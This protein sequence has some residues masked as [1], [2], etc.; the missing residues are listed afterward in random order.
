MTFRTN[1]STATT[2]PMPLSL[3]HGIAYALP[4]LT[5][6]LLYGP[7]AIMQGIYAKYFGVALTTIATVILVARLFDALSDPLIGYFSDRYYARRGSRKPFV[8]IGGLLLIFSSYFLYVPVDPDAV[9]ASTTISTSYFLGWFLMF[10]LAYTLFEVPHLAW[11]GELSADSAGKNKIFS[12]RVLFILLGQ[13]IF[14][15]TPLL[16]MF[17]DHEFTPHTLKWSVLTAGV[18]MLPVLYFCVKAVPN[19]QSVPVSSDHKCSGGGN[20]SLRLVWSSIIDNTPFVIFITAYF[21][22]MVGFGMWYGLLFSYSDAYLGLSHK[23]P[24]IYGI[25]LSVS[26]LSIGVWHK[27]AIHWGKK[28]TWILGILIASLGIVSTGLLVPGIQHWVS[29]CV[30]MTFIYVGFM[31]VNI[32]APSWLADIIDYG[33]WKFGSDHAGSYFSLYT[34]TQKVNVAIGGALG[35]AI[36]A[37][38]GFDPTLTVHNVD[39]VFG[40]Q[41]AIVW[42]PLGIVLLSTVFVALIPMNA[43]RHATI[44]RRLQS[45]RERAVAQEECVGIHQKLT[46]AEQQTLTSL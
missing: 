8:V 25:S 9:T 11:G 32:L 45:R 29:L 33:T 14:F 42:I 39:V 20:E 17:E 35:L 22:I 37:W 3:Q 44:S 27:L 12:L 19:G 38:Y 15:S 7:V 40:V 13:I 24:L 43:R 6:N 36:A 31:A 34:L 21:F 2:I 46:D 18:L 1:Q 16:P 5:V 41:L 10:Y 26:V 23:L 28:L 30:C 4:A